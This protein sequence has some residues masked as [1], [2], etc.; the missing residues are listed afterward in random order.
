MSWIIANDVLVFNSAFTMDFFC[1]QTLRYQYFEIKHAFSKK[2]W[3]IVPNWTWFCCMFGFSI[4]MSCL[5]FVHHI[6]LKSC[7]C[8]N[9]L[10]QRDQYKYW[11]LYSCMY[12]FNL[13][14][15]MSFIWALIYYYIVSFVK[16]SRFLIKCKELISV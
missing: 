3:F 6:Y 2:W 11:Y 15:K 10:H 1:V 16:Y 9:G 12:L 8:V 5:H 4:W 14:S 13:I 7:S